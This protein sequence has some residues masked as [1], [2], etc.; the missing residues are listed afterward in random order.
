VF[1][2]GWEKGILLLDLLTVAGGRRGRTERDD[3]HKGAEERG[4]IDE[5]VS[6]PPWERGMESGV[7]LDGGVTISMSGWVCVDVVVAPLGREPS[8][9]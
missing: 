3:G 2:G 1:E 4:E 8:S 6:L 7:L 5:A 9:H